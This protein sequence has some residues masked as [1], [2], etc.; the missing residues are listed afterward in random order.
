M[1]LERGLGELAGLEAAEWMVQGRGRVYVRAGRKRRVYG[2]LRE[3]RAS[4]V[5]SCSDALRVTFAPGADAALYTAFFDSFRRRT[6]PGEALVK[7]RVFL[8]P[9]GRFPSPIEIPPM[10]LNPVRQEILQEALLEMGGGFP[11]GAGGAVCGAVHLAGRKNRGVYLVNA[12]T[13][14]IETLSLRNVWAKRVFA[15]DSRT[16][17]VQAF[18][19]QPDKDGV[20]L[21]LSLPSMEAVMLWWEQDEKE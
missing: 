17:T 1:L 15:F 18:L 5:I 12:S 11:D 6:A 14:D 10:L 9:F 8:Y 4:A 16:K 2:G 19:T 3:A 20:R 13:E 21:A 7:G